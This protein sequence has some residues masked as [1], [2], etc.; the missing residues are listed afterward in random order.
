M[1]IMAQVAGSGTGDPLARVNA[2]TLACLCED[3]PRMT[4]AQGSVVSRAAIEMLGLA[5]A[6]VR[7]ARLTPRLLK[8]MAEA[9]IDVSRATLYRAFAPYGGVTRFINDLRLQHAWVLLTSSDQLPLA[10]IAARCGYVTRMRLSQAFNERFAMQPD[11]VLSARGDRA[12][13]RESAAHAMMDVWDRRSG[14]TN[15]G[16]RT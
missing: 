16:L 7:R 13:L 15:V 3:A 12:T 4:Q 9:L 1:I 10:E 11:A 8:V 14:R 2:S 6:D 5:L